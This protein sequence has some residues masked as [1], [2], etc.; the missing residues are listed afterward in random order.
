MS[1]SIVKKFNH[2]EVIS[3]IILNWAY[4]M[5]K[6]IF[7]ILIIS[8]HLSICLRMEWS[9]HSKFN[10]Q[11]PMQPL[12]KPPMNLL[13]LSL[14]IFNGTP[15][16]FKTWTLNN[17]IISFVIT[18]SCGWDKMNHFGQFINT[19]KYYVMPLSCGN[20]TNYEI[21]ICTFPFFLKDL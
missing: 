6:H 12:P 15:W 19:H 3:P 1:W 11:K 4:I 16:I 14:I 18:K 13:F 20:K 7:K 10:A 8:F 17:L 5:I 2:K 9:W 21:H